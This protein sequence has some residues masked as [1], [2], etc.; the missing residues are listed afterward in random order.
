[1]TLV[2]LKIGGGSQDPCRCQPSELLGKTRSSSSREFSRKQQ[3]N[4]SYAPKFSI[5][6]H[7]HLHDT[8]PLHSLML[9]T[10]IR[11]VRGLSNRPVAAAHGRQWQAAAAVARPAGL[12]ARVS[13][14]LL[15]SRCSTILKVRNR[16]TNE[17]YSPSLR[18]TSQ[19]K[20][21]RSPS[22]QPPTQTPLTRP[23]H[24]H[25]QSRPMSPTRRFPPRMC[26]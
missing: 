12:A 5:P 1:M 21:R 16:L 11:S 3:E 15:V 8:R 19:M 13:L 25:R 23:N 9:R 26:P 18:D 6:P 20:S 4:R 24:H 14:K 10:S 2:V 22:H 17:F 7:H